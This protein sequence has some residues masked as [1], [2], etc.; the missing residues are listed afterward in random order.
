MPRVRPRALGISHVA[1]LTRDLDRAERFYVGLLGLD[2]LVRYED[3]Q[4]RHRST[5]VALDERTFLAIERATA[6]GQGRGDGDVGH[7]CLALRIAAADRDSWRRQLAA[8]D[9]TVER[10]SK[11]TLYV[12]DPDGTLIGLSHYPEES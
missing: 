6:D 11:F 10:E 7:H 3:D 4:G 12:R 5:W 1:I 2:V 9:V 8:A